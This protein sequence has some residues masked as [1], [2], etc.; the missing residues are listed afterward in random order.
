MAP[1]NET[2]SRASDGETVTPRATG[3]RSLR[4]LAV[5]GVVGVCAVAAAAVP[6]TAGATAGG[7]L[8]AVDT[9]PAPQQLR[10]SDIFTVAPPTVVLPPTP[11]PSFKPPFTL[12]PRPTLIFPGTGS[13]ATT[14][15][16]T[17]VT[18]APPTTPTGTP[19][20]ALPTD[21]TTTTPATATPTVTITSNPL[22]QTIVIVA[23][24]QLITVPA[25]Q[26]YVTFTG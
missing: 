23:P 24:Q 17:T 3:R 13:P 7:R 21:T 11:T 15:P 22:S 14:P 16:T 25:V 5:L 1:D 2:A 9:T 18:T 19:T 6:A 20:S 26:S 8:P 12:G 4:V 10:P